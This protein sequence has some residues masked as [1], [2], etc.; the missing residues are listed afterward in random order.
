MVVANPGCKPASGKNNSVRWEDGS[1]KRCLQRVLL[2]R[3][4][5]GGAGSVEGILLDK[6]YFSNREGNGKD[7]AREEFDNAGQRC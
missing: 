6:S 4:A 3:N 2:Q 1:G 5:A 7:A